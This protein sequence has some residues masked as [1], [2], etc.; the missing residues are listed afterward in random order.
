MKDLF[1]GW[2][3]E[4]GLWMVGDLLMIAVGIAALLLT[5]THILG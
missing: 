2:W 3:G 5:L 4:R 1:R